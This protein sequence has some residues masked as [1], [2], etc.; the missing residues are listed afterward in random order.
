LPEGWVWASVDELVAESS[1]GTSVKCSYESNGTPVLRIPNVSAGSLDLRDMKF[2]VD[3]LRN[4]R[5]TD[6][7]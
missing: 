2:A 6:V 1:Y 5:F 3:D 7:V 4:L